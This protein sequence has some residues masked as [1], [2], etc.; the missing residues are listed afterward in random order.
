ML[1]LGAQLFVNGKGPVAQPLDLRSG[2]MVACTGAQP[3]ASWCAVQPEAGLSMPSKAP[4]TAARLQAG[5]LALPAAARRL[6]GMTGLPDHPQLEAPVVAFSRQSSPSGQQEPSSGQGR[7]G[8]GGCG[9]VAGVPH[10]P[11]PLPRC[12][13]GRFW[14]GAAKSRGKRRNSPH[15]SCGMRGVQSRPALMS[16]DGAAASHVDS[17]DG[18]RSTRYWPLFHLPPLA[19]RLLGGWCGSHPQCPIGLADR[20]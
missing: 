19:P 15:C 12:A 8:G 3:A 13:T 9:S 17:C 10:Q 14:G 5:G 20:R 18:L 11:P 7:A 6:S 1:G 4:V 16:Q 2:K